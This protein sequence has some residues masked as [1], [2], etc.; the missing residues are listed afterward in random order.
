MST[1]IIVLIA[2]ILVVVIS[3]VIKTVH[4]ETK[5]KD[6]IATISSLILGGL[7]AVLE[8]G[9]IEEL[10]AGGILGTVILVYG[11]GQLFYKYLSR[12][13]GLDELLETKIKG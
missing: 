5:T 1:A 6:L 12:P 8:A 9:S 2:A 7:A 13:T 3:S 4:M 10:T 11:S